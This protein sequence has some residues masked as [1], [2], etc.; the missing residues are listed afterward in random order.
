MSTGIKLVA[1]FDTNVFDNI[2][3]RSAGVLQGDE[4]HLLKAIESGRLVVVTSILNISETMDARRPEIVLPQL[5]LIAKLADRD[6]FVKPH[7]VVLTDDVRHFAW[8]GEPDSPF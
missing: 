7:D 4:A 2:L 6:R 1:Y 3:K 8:N 5:N